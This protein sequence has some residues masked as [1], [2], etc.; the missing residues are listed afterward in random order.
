MNDRAQLS[1]RA[2]L[3]KFALFALGGVLATLTHVGTA[4]LLLGASGVFILSYLGG[5]ALAFLVSF[6]FHYTVTFRGVRIP[7]ILVAPQFFAIA[8]GGC[9]LSL[10]A[11]APLATHS[12]PLGLAVGAGLIPIIS[13]LGA[14][15]WA[16]AGHDP[17]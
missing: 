1:I 16:F 10:V 17:S 11:A 12:K 2:E 3:S 15:F 9:A 7:L 6:A 13:F 4:F 8:A 5:F 14:R